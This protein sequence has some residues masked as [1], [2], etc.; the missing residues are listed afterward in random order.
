MKLPL[1]T[2]REDLPTSINPIK[3]M[4][5]RYVY[6]SVQSRHFHIKRLPPQV[7]LDYVK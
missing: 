4:L 6:G 3:K 7:T 5:H 2:F 1:F